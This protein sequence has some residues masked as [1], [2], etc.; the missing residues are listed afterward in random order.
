MQ[1]Q[2]LE[3]SDNF[4]LHTNWNKGIVPTDKYMKCIVEQFLGK[5]IKI[6]GIGYDYENQIDKQTSW[7][8]WLP[9][10]SI[11]IIKEIL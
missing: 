1:K 5:M 11:T 3:P 8:G 10:D 7:E 9:T 4:T 6:T 2:L